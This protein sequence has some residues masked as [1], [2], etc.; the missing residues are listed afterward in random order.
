MVVDRQMI[1]AA[2]GGALVDKTLVVVRQL[3]EI[4]AFNNQQFHTHN[5]FVVLEFMI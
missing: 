3:I 4:M 2:S 1:D 5:N